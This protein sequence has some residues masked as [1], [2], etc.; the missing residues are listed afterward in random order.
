MTRKAVTSSNLRSVGY[1]PA[2]R[3]LE[4]EFK[5][6]VY[7]YADVPLEEYE[8]LMAAGSHGSYFIQNIRDAY[9]VSRIS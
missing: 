1:D 5:N 6:G 2:T 8:A 9:S 3:T 4:I 7:Q